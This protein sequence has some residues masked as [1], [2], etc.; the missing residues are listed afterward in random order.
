VNDSGAAREP[1]PLLDTPTLSKGRGNLKT[2]PSAPCESTFLKLLVQ[3][4]RRV[5]RTFKVGE[6]V[7]NRVRASSA[8]HA[9]EWLCH[10]VYNSG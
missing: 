10:W 4:Q 5:T 9:G 1:Y 7:D 3:P 2:C 6:L 8:A